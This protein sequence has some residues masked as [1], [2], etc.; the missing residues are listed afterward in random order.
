M[1]K[2]QTLFW[3]FWIFFTISFFILVYIQRNT[4]FIVLPTLKPLYIVVLIHFTLFWIFMIMLAI[5]PIWQQD[6]QN[7]IWSSEIS[8]QL[9]GR[10]DMAI[11]QISAILVTIFGIY[12]VEVKFSIFLLVA[13][14]GQVFCKEV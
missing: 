12:K 7:S 8:C 4:F 11:R 9:F 2:S 13:I 14:L 3:L 10:A 5:R 6:F 1:A